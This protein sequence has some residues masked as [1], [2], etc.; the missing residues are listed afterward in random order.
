[1]WIA[2]AARPQVERATE[3]AR[4]RALRAVDVAQARLAS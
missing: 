3:L 1:M 4:E 2:E